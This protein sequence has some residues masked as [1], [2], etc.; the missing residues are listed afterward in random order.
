MVVY[1]TKINWNSFPQRFEIFTPMLSQKK[2]VEINPSF[3]M[4]IE[5][6]NWDQLENF[7]CD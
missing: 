3:V 6:K 1:P 7:R 5:K 2:I 4:T